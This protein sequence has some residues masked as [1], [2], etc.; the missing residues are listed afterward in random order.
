MTYV[1]LLPRMRQCL[2]HWLVNL[3]DVPKEYDSLC[4]FLVK[5]QLLSNCPNDLRIFLK[6][7][8][9]DSSVDMAQAADRYRSAHRSTRIRNTFQAKVNVEGF[10]S[11]SNVKCQNCQKP[12]HIRLNCPELKATPKH[13]LPSK[14]NNVFESNVAPETTITDVGTVFNKPAKVL[15]DTGCSIIIVKD[16][17][18]PLNI[19]RG[20]YVKLYDYLGFDKSFPEVRCFIKSKFIN[21]WVR[22][23]AAPIKF[24][25][26][27]IGMVQGV[28]LPSPIK[29]PGEKCRTFNNGM[30]KVLGVQ[31]R[32]QAPSPLV[33]PE[34]SVGNLSRSDLIEAQTNCPSLDKIRRRVVSQNLVSVKHCTVKYEKVNGLICC[35]CVKSRNEHEIGMIQLVVP[36]NLRNTVNSS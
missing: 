12:G 29:Q 33:V 21:G 23:V 1:Q 16:S 31:T 22:A 10:Q 14:I 26:V 18:I 24:T 8:S 27:L 20:K 15:F 32:A 9:F 7:R 28:K 3:S 11:K 36:S 13:R 2:D 34:I 6:E 30:S 17:L 25:D 5:D 19:K 35:I 4:E